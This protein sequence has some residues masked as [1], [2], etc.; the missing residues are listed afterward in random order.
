[1]LV[2]EVRSPSTEHKDTR[3]VK[4]ICGRFSIDY[5]LVTP[6]TRVGAPWESIERFPFGPGS[7]ID[8]PDAS[9]PTAAVV[10]DAG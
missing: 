4:G 7:G 2:A 8:V 3:V 10:V 5:R 9:G 6:S 1:V